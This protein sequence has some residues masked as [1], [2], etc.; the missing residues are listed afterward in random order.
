M[1]N[2]PFLHGCTFEIEGGRPH[3]HTGLSVPLTFTLVLL[4]PLPQLL[5]APGMWTGVSRLPLLTWT[6]GSTF[7]KGCEQMTVPRQSSGT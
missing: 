5:L 3:I 2:Y 1:Q 7:L 4:A 6:T